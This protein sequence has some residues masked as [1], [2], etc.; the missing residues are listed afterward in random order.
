MKRSSQHNSVI[1]VTWSH[2][3]ISCCSL[4]CVR[5]VISLTNCLHLRCSQMLPGPSGTT[6]RRTMLDGLHCT[7]TLVSRS[8]T[9]CGSKGRRWFVSPADICQ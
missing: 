1:T 8:P 5:Y 6:W 7:Q 2:S 4:S 3:S 9:S